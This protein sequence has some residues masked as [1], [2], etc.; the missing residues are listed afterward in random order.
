MTKQHQTFLYSD[1]ADAIR[2]EISAWNKI[3]KDIPPHQ[4]LVSYPTALAEAGTW[5]LVDESMTARKLL[6]EAELA[7]LNK[8]ND[9]LMT[10]NMHSMTELTKTLRLLGSRN[11]SKITE[12]RMKDLINLVDCLFEDA[13][14]KNKDIPNLLREQKHLTKDERE[15]AAWIAENRLNSNLRQNAS[16]MQ[17]TKQK[18]DAKWPGEGRPITVGEAQQAIDQA[19]SDLKKTFQKDKRKP[20]W[21]DPEYSMSKERHWFWKFCFPYVTASGIIGY[22]VTHFIR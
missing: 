17:D 8:L 7:R 15:E 4:R 13:T 2:D 16:Q 5:A 3:N 21:L 22:I 18:N 1:L 20:K 19:M 12:S 10:Q 9:E 11:G 14:I 6:K